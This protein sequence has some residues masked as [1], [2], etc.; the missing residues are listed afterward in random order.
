MGYES[1][2]FVCWGLEA[3][4]VSTKQFLFT[5]QSRRHYILRVKGE[6]ATEISEK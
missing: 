5:L 3:E 1:G 4:L 2:K 6:I